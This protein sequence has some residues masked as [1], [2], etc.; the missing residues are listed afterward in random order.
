MPDVNRQWLLQR[1]PEP[2]ELLSTDHFRWHESEVPTPGDGE[3]VVRTIMLGTSPAQRAYT[4]KQQR[5]HGGLQVGDNM[6]SRG[7]GVVTESRH[8]DFGPGDV[9][10]GSLG[11]QDYS[12]QNAE[13]TAVAGVNVK[14]V[15]R[16]RPEVRPLELA[17]GTL[18]SAAITAYVGLVDTGDVRAGDTVVISAAAGGVGS[19]AVQIARLH[20]CR[21]V[22]IA[23][24]P[25]KCAWLTD[26]LGCDAAVDYRADDV[27]AALDRHC[28]NG[29]DVYF[30]NV[31]GDLLE[32]CLERINVGARVVLCG[33]IS[34][35]YD[36]E[37][38]PGPAHYFKLLYQRATMRGFV[39]WDHVQRFDSI[40]RGLLRWYERGWLQPTEDIVEGLE[41][42][43]EALADL[44]R[45]QNRGIRL[46]RV[47]PDP[48]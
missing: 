10:S 24:G 27:R 9:V 12:V 44:F 31:G 16:V 1:H 33:Y 47:A 29:V 8:P 26:T 43:P 3:F 37:P 21:V 34:S 18:G 22:G 23:G 45:G 14:A 38:A 7:V 28:P 20:G 17:L 40:Q 32:A 42:A 36:A 25:D 6:R 11:W 2:T 46:V 19:M 30:D 39:V 15:Q 48:V 41:N 5:F 4:L 35:E 13:G